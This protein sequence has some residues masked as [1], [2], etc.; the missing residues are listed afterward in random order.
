MITLGYGDIVPT[1]FSE[2]IVVIGVAFL[3]CGMFAYSFNK[4]GTIFQSI[5]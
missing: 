1:T 2:R 4:I 3:A 5:N